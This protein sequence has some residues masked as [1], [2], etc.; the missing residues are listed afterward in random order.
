MGKQD[1]SAHVS[2]FRLSVFVWAGLFALRY[3]QGTLTPIEGPVAMIL[4]PLFIMELMFT[5]E[6]IE[7]YFKRARKSKDK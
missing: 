5:A 6:D 3:Y 4:L 1:T 7:A 2:L